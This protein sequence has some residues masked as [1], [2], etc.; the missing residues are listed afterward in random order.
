MAFVGPVAVML[1]GAVWSAL[2]GWMVGD[3]AD[4]RASEGAAS[5]GG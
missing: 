1:V 2:F 4:V 5:T 3:D